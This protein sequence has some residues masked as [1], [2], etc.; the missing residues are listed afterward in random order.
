MN[1][2]ALNH[3]I[4][5]LIRIEYDDSSGELFLVFQVTDEDFKRRV[6]EDWM[7][8][9]DLKLLNKKLIENK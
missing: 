6:K 5:S 2:K 8:D 1:N 9:I 3:T 4:A 7:Q